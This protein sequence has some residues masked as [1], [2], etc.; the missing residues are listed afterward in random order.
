[1]L[2][3]RSSADYRSICPVQT[4]KPVRVHKKTLALPRRRLLSARPTPRRRLNGGGTGPGSS[5]YHVALVCLG[6]LSAPRCQLFRPTTDGGALQS[7]PSCKKARGVSE[8]AAPQAVA[9]KNFSSSGGGKEKDF[10]HLHACL[11]A[12]P[13]RE[14]LWR[15]C[16]LGR[17]PISMCSC[18]KCAHGQGTLS[19]ATT[20]AGEGQ[21]L[22]QR[23]WELEESLVEKAGRSAAGSA[24]EAAHGGAQR[25]KGGHSFHLRRARLFQKR[26]RRWS[27][28][29]PRIPVRC[30]AAPF[31]EKRGTI[32][33]QSGLGGLFK[34]P[35]PRAVRGS[36]CRLCPRHAHCVGEPPV[37]KLL[38]LPVRHQVGEMLPLPAVPSATVLGLHVVIPVPRNCPSA[39]SNICLV[40]ESGPM[41]A[42]SH[43]TCVFPCLLSVLSFFIK[44]RHDALGNRN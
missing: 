27:C 22:V 8:K 29:L 10:N 42:M 9:R 1:M 11:P 24:D 26:R 13:F 3:S 35:D 7:V 40:S 5:G 14:K 33:R 30:E 16:S 37:K 20:T 44:A 38:S 32:R 6:R 36:A 17:K 4:R 18:R 43:P 15:P 25:S 23:G 39:N 19:P 28:Q 12:I 31:T 34:P 21:S 2:W 41:L